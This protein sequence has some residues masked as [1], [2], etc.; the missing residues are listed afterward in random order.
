MIDSIEK[1]EKLENLSVDPEINL[2][3]DKD[4]QKAKEISRSSNTRDK[5]YGDW[6]KFETYCKE[7]HN[8]GFD[9]NTLS[10]VDKAE[11]ISAKYIHVYH[12]MLVGKF[13]RLWRAFVI[14]KAIQNTSF[15]RK[16][17]REVVK[18]AF[19]RG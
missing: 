9:P 10:T 16:L 12:I 1:K 11:K 17:Y 8:P 13:A 5:Y 4:F 18:N 14:I 2:D 3:D 6:K 15:P 7:I 19:N